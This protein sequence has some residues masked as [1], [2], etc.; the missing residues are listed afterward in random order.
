MGVDSNKMNRLLILVII[1]LLVALIVSINSSRSVVVAGTGSSSG[2]VAAVTGNTDSQSRDLLY[3]IDTD[4][5]SL[6]VYEYLGG[7]LNMVAA[8]NIKFDLL[9][10]EWRPR[11]QKPSVKEIYEETRKKI[12]KDST[13][14]KKK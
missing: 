7:R 4:A 12:Q 14:P 10:D 3:V 2:G 8:R 9:L 13:P 5:K 1:G 11:S 6:C